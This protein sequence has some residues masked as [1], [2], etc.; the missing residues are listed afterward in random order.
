[1]HPSP[2]PYITPI[3]DIWVWGNRWQVVKK[4]DFG[5]I[6]ISGR[7][8]KYESRYSQHGGYYCEQPIISQYL[9]TPVEFSICGLIE[10]LY[11]GFVNSL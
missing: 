1:M 6:V 9:D 2:I 3:F 5:L 11:L 10:N 8:K 7:V 4:R